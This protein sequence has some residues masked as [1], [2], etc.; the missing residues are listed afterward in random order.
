MYLKHNQKTTISSCFK[1][2]LTS[3][4]IVAEVLRDWYQTVADIRGIFEFDKDLGVSFS[5]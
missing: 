5:S 2:S 3:G 4:K 1:R